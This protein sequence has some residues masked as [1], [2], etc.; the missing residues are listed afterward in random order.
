MQ[1]S[2][3]S[4]GYPNCVSHGSNVCLTHSPAAS[5][6]KKGAGL[7]RCANPYILF[8]SQANGGLYCPVHLCLITSRNYR[9][10][11][12]H[13]CWSP[14]IAVRFVAGH[15]LQH[16]DSTSGRMFL[17]ASDVKCVMF[18]NPGASKKTL[19]GVMHSYCTGLIVTLYTLRMMMDVWV[20]LPGY[21]YT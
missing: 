14:D 15:L 13:S 4:N 18:D 10:P 16:E 7:A 20:E 2:I 8:L 11:E 3:E 1:A 19:K 17:P 21:E 5:Y 6:L 9:A 12:W